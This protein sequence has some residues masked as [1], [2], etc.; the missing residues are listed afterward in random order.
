MT[1]AEEYLHWATTEQASLVAAGRTGGQQYR[2]CLLHVEA[3]T[4]IAADPALAATPRAPRETDIRD[5]GVRVLP[6]AELA[7]RKSSPHV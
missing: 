6:P 2:A 3:A 1:P 7:R 4:I 5:W